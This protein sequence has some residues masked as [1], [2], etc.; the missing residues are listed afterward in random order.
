MTCT[1]KTEDCIRN[2][3]PIDKVATWLALEAYNRR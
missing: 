3:D 1:S 2:D